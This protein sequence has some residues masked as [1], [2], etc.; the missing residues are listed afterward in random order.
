MAEN[1]TVA[2][3]LSVDDFIANVDD[4]GRKADA[5]TLRELMERTSGS[6]AVMWGPSIIG[7]GSYRYKS[8][9]TG[10]EGDW[11]LIGFSPRKAA[12]SLYGLHYA[13]AEQDFAETLGKHTT[14]KGC[15]YVKRLSDVDPVVLE[16]LIA[17]AIARGPEYAA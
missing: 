1:K 14:S 11:M 7:F 9:A 5:V 6:P 3:A 12:L 13:Y 2:N 4:A 15:I 17:A 8:A 10:R 16:R